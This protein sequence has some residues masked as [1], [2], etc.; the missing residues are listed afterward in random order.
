MDKEFKIAVSL[1][2]FLLIVSALL[3][4]ILAHIGL[5]SAGFV[6]G[7]V[8]FTLLLAP[9]ILFSTHF[10]VQSFREWISGSF[11][12]KMLLPL[13]V[14]AVYGFSSLAHSSFDSF[15]LFKLSLWVFVPSLI[16][17]FDLMKGAPPYL[18]E[19]AVALMLW[20][21]IELG[22]LSGFDIIF[23]DGIQIPALAFA[24]PVFGLYLFAVLADLPDI[25]YHFRWRLSDI[26]K[27]AAALAVLAVLLIRMGTRL[28]FIR[29]STLDT[30]FADVV[31]LV[32]GI[33]FMVAIPEELLFRGIIQN[34][35]SK[36]L[37]RFKYSTWLSL[38]IASAIFGLSHYNNFNPPDWRYVFLATIA[39]LFYGW[40]YIRTGKTTVSALVH[41]GVNFFW[42][43]LFKDTGG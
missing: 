23:T 38:L 15:L 16:L 28:G 9:Y 21:P 6:N 10:C 39:G 34:V 27:A 41:C 2:V 1:L 7:F 24:A 14:L 8:P 18:K 12:K 13:G 25:G 5:F 19:F 43:I 17:T 42:A 3:L 29:F 20:L 36:A 32:L 30:S 22:K 35:L 40:T 11:T 26:G 31:K 4:R 37:S 33:Y